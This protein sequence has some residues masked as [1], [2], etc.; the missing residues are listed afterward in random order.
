ML[1]LRDEKVQVGLEW[2]E[3]RRKGLCTLTPES[4]QL[5]R[6]DA[7][8]DRLVQ[9]PEDPAAEQ[10]PCLLLPLPDPEGAQVHSL[11]QRVAPRPEALQPAHQHHL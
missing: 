1:S 3:F 4:A 7:D 11:C 9:A 10:R 2:N 5:H 6:P 8:G